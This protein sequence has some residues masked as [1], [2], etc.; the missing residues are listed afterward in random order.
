LIIAARQTRYD[1]GF[2]IGILGLI[3]AA[4][5][6]ISDSTNIILIIGST[7]WLVLSID[8]F[9]VDEAAWMSWILAA[10]LKEFGATSKK[11]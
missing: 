7:S 8:T 6:G 5:G 10:I 3:F 9:I 1:S 4:P 2:A 11:E